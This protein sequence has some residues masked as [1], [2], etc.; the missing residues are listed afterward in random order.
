[1]LYGAM[2]VLLNASAL[3]QAEWAAR[4]EG[5]LRSERATAI[6]QYSVTMAAQHVAWHF[7]S[8]SVEDFGRR[9]CTSVVFVDSFCTFFYISG[10]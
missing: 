10:E 1:L 2:V 6:G 4:R 9:H 7:D 5:V 8:D 3:A